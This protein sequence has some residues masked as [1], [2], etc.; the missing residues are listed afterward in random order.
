GFDVLSP[1]I[2]VVVQQQ[3]DS[4]TAGVGFS[5]NPLTNDY[6]EAVINA[7]WGLGE[8]VVSG[9]VTPD[10]FIV[11]KVDRE[12]LEQ[13]LGTKQISTRLGPDGGTIQ[14]KDHRSHEPSLD[15]GQ[16]CELTEMICRIEALY[17]KPMDIEWAYADGRLHI[18][19]ARPI[20]AY[21]PL[22]P[23]MLTKPGER[24][25]LYAD[26][27]LSQGLTINGPISPLGLAWVMGMLYS[28]MMERFL[29]IR[30]FTP[31][32]GMVFSAG[33]RFYMNLSNTMR[34]G[35]TPKAMAKNTALTDAL[36]AEILANIDSKQYRAETRP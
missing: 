34:L 28:G 13:K 14:R 18:L 35:M 3:I 7:N 9:A 10:Y 26:A 6:D 12:I 25:R 30:D 22:P 5:L 36:L 19:Q 16:L 15:T 11:G 2:A 24:R 23:E 32:G 17:E 1:R 33:C 21:V 4:E 8:S 31:A 27:G 29:G 20:T